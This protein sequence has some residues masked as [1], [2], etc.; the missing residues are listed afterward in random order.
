[1]HEHASISRSTLGV[2]SGALMRLDDFS[3]PAEPL[4]DYLRGI[5]GSRDTISGIARILRHDLQLASLVLE[6]EDPADIDA[7]IEH[8][9]FETI[10]NR[11][12]AIRLPAALGEPSQVNGESRFDWTGFW[13]HSLAVAAAARSLAR[14]RPELGVSPE[15]AFLAGLIHDLGKVALANL[16]PRGFVRATEF[17]RQ[18]RCDLQ[19]SESAVLGITHTLAG[20]RVAERWGLPEALREVIWLHHYSHAGTIA[21]AQSRELVRIVYAANRL[22]HARSLGDS[23]NPERAMELRELATETNISLAD[24]ESAAATGQQATAAAPPK[25][26]TAADPRN[27]ATIRNLVALETENGRLQTISRYFA[28]LGQLDQELYGQSNACDVLRAALGA[29]SHLW[30]ARP[31]GAFAASETSQRICVAHVREQRG[32]EQQEYALRDHLRAV[33]ENSA[34]GASRMFEPVPREIR[35]LLGPM[36]LLESETV[37]LARIARG[38]AC[39]G[40]IVV[41]A[42]SRFAEEMEAERDECVALFNRIGLALRRAD[43]YATTQRLADELADS[44]RL[45]QANQSEMLRTRSL[46]MIAELAAGAGHELNNPLSVIS[47]RAQLLLRD[48]PG[49]SEAYRSLEQILAKSHECSRIVSDLMDFARPR[50]PVMESIAAGDLLSAISDQWKTRL[51]GNIRLEAIAPGPGQSQALAMVRGDRQQLLQV[52]DELISNAVDALEA[53]GGHVRVV[54]RAA[55]RPQAAGLSDPPAKGVE[56]TVS[57]DGVGM[58]QSVLHRAFDPFFSYRPAGRRRGLGL[59]R[60]H[61]ILD[62]HS[63]RIWIES[64]VSTGTQVHV[65]IPSA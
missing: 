25:C 50:P 58:T 35:L 12:L 48:V 16:F 63:G 38:N 24:L 18:N 31:V 22:A 7:A 14:A 11:M 2:E 41:S 62:A 55:S 19:S 8:L 28:A 57:D 33:L 49:D 10:R 46:S 30:R 32:V 52:F 56:F 47:G 65:F 43:A 9:G 6:S 27:A 54:A 39:L 34:S 42:G 45:L 60:V 3:P 21:S 53:R 37:W 51:R 61:R 1:M 17:A 23:G 44:N 40:G 13:R 15:T 5:P 20:R 36:S 59:T 4:L 64:S 26:T 29:I